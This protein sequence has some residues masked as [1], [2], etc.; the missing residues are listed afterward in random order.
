MN[1]LNEEKFIGSFEG[2]Y[3]NWGQIYFINQRNGVGINY[4]NRSFLWRETKLWRRRAASGVAVE[5][6]GAQHC[7]WVDNQK[8]FTDC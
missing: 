6:K 7:Q 4:G 8:I 1:I 2:I 3:D 5:A